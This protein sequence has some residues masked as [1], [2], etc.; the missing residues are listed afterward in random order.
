[1]FDWTWLPR[2][3][4]IPL[5][6]PWDSSSPRIITINVRHSKLTL[7]KCCSQQRS[8]DNLWTFILNVFRGLGLVFILG[9]KTSSHLFWVPWVVPAGLTHCLWVTTV[10]RRMYLLVLGKKERTPGQ[11]ICQSVELG[12]LQNWADYFESSRSPEWGDHRSC[13]GSVK[14][15]VVVRIMAALLISDLHRCIRRLRK[16]TREADG[17]VSVC[18]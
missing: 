11:K 17:A 10:P 14:P 1:M 12:K 4:H 16:L 7:I 5:F 3:S 15:Q 8:F 6:S 9:R 2:G 18:P 13:Q